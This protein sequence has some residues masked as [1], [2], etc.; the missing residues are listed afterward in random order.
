MAAFFSGLLLCQTQV[1]A[2]EET[3]DEVIEKVAEKT[4]E[5]ISEKTNKKSLEKIVKTIEEKA[6]KKALQKA[7]RPE[8]WKGPT[9]VYFVVFVLDIDDIDGAAQSFAANVFVKLRWKDERL[10]KEGSLSR[11]IPLE[12]V[13]NPRI[14]LAN[15]GGIVRQSLPKVV[16]VGPDGTVIYRQRYIGPISQPLNLSEF[17]M[18]QH[19]FTIQFTAVGHIGH[20]LEFIPDTLQSKGEVLGGGMAEELSVP[21]WKILKYEGIAH[22][23]EPIEQIQAAGFAFEFTAKRFFP[24][25]LW[26]VVI[27]LMVIVG[28]SWAAFW[29]DPSQAGAQIGLAGSSILSLIAYRFVLGSL[30]PRLPYMTRMDYLTLGGTMLVF[31]ALIQVIVTTALAHKG[32]EVAARRIDRA[33]RLL[34]PSAF[35]ILFIWSLFL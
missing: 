15:Q 4:A 8:G 34:F 35:V 5:K 30:L 27:P 24:Y 31:M 20:E 6:E 2:A 14:I 16:Q 25:Y 10:V 32:Q 21:D 12:D 9:K 22:P 18:D 11:Q 13:W 7:E 3:S 33:C 19:R 26:Q 23:F 28:M 29:I 1:W 17:P